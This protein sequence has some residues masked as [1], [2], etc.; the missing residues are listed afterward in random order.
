M[1]SSDTIQE[2]RPPESFEVDGVA[3]KNVVQAKGL[4]KRECTS[5]GRRRIKGG[6]ELAL[7]KRNKTSSHNASQAHMFVAP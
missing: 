5:K 7:A 4:K 6:L 2:E 3:D 1:P